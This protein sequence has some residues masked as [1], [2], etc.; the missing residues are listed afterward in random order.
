MVGGVA[1]GLPGTGSWGDPQGHIW[2][3][4]GVLP[5]ALDQIRASST[6]QL[7]PKTHP[8]CPGNGDAAERGQAAARGSAADRALSAALKGGATPNRAPR[9][10]HGEQRFLWTLREPRRAVFAAAQ[11]EPA[12]EP[13]LPSRHGRPHCADGPPRVTCRCA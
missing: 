7:Q 1:T 11:G 13:P 9:G 2:V 3:P 5:T 12:S 8:S 10:A 4:S 6:G